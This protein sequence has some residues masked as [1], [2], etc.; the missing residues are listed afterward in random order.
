MQREQAQAIIGELWRRAKDL[1]HSA[2]A[3]GLVLD[4]A[5]DQA[6]DDLVVDLATQSGMGGV[7]YSILLARV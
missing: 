3:L 5:I 1:P 2:M 4:R 7:G 6:S